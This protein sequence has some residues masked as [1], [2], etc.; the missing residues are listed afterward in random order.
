MSYPSRTVFI[1][2]H[3]RTITFT[4]FGHTLDFPKYLNLLGVEYK[5]QIVKDDKSHQ[6]G[7]VFEA[8]VFYKFGDYH[9]RI[10]KSWNLNYYRQ[11]HEFLMETATRL[12]KEFNSKFGISTCFP[13][14]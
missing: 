12:A 3:Y 7:L 11:G 9:R 5:Y 10:L 13:Q 1:P 4:D 8:S 2:A 6:Y 14:C